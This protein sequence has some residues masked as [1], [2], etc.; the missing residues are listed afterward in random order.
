M[1]SAN[2]VAEDTRNRA[3][4][5]RNDD[6]ENTMIASTTREVAETAGAG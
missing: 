5:F 3:P 6:G 1:V 4:V 2:P